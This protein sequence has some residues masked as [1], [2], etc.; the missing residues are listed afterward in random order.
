MF[1]SSG[2]VFAKHPAE[3]KDGYLL[4]EGDTIFGKLS[5]SETE[6]ELIPV[7]GIPGLRRVN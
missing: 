1:V 3:F 6:N 5:Y 2:I 7:N 4:I